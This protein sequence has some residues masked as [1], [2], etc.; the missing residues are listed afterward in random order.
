[1]VCTLLNSMMAQPKK[2][3]REIRGAKE[4]NICQWFWVVTLRL[5]TR[6]L[7]DQNCVPN[8]GN[9]YQGWVFGSFEFQFGSLLVCTEYRTN[10][11]GSVWFF[12]IRFFGMNLI[13]RLF[14][15]LKWVYIFNLNGLFYVFFSFKICTIKLQRQLPQSKPIL[16]FAKNSATL[17]VYALMQPHSST[18]REPVTVKSTTQQQQLV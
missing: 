2:Q 1:M 7:N 9:K 8:R 5:T 13:N 18:K 16:L 12:L 6:Q 17:L 10:L 11:I 4:D 15:N 14:L 3:I